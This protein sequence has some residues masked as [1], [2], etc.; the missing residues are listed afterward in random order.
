MRLEKFMLIRCIFF[1]ELRDIETCVKKKLIECYF[2]LVI[3][4]CQNNEIIDDLCRH[5]DQHTEFGGI[6]YNGEQF[7]DIEYEKKIT[8]HINDKIKY[9]IDFDK[10]L[11][12]YT[13]EFFDGDFIKKIISIDP[14]NILL[15]GYNKLTITNLSGPG[16][17]YLPE[18]KN[19]DLDKYYNITVTKPITLHR[20]A[21]C[22]Y[23]L[24]HAKSWKYEEMFT[25]A[26]V[27]NK[28][29][30]LNVE[31]KFIHHIM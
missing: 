25:F 28:N 27:I 11:E 14:K 4:I 2:D 31:L 26:Q 24:R 3:D 30:I 12:V 1:D 29:G 9:V 8:S 22:Y 20:L 17:F 16:Y 5:V 21:N 7:V 23:K 19:I 6:I 10:K 15:I 18:F 13:E